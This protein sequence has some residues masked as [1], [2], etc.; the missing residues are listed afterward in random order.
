M[1]ERAA[2]RTPDSGQ[3]TPPPAAGSLTAREA[4][5]AVGVHERTVRRAI[6]RGE[7]AAAQHAGVYRIAPAD[8]ARYQERRRIAAPPG[9]QTDRP[10]PGLI[11]FPDAE[12]A[13]A[14][15]LPRPRSP[16]IGR[17]RELAAVR[18]LLLRE[19]VP[20]VTL[21]G[22]GGVGKTR[23]A[24][25]AAADLGD[26]FADG[27]W[28]VDLAPLA[29]P[30]MVPAAIAAVLGVREAGDRPLP[31]RLNAYLARRELLLLLDNFEGVATAAP[32]VAALLAAC[33][34]VT[35][36]VTSRA[37][38]RVS[39][40]HRFPVPP[41]ALTDP[42]TAASPDEATASAAVRLFAARARAVAPDFAVTAANAEAVAEVCRRLDGLPLAIELAAARSNLLAPRALLARLEARLPVLTGG[43]RDQ[44][45][46]LQTMRAAIA[47]GY[48][49]LAPEEQTLFRRLAVFAGGFAPEA[50]EWVMGTARRPEACPSPA[51]VLDGIASL[52][53][54]S[55]V[56]REEADEEEPRFSLLDTIREFAWEQVVAGDE[57]DTVA[58]AHA[59]WC[60]DLAER[61]RL[62]AY[63]PDGE[64]QLDRL[65]TEH[66]NLRAALAWLDRRGDGDRLLR[67]AAA[68][69]EYW[70]ARSHLREG[71]AWFERALAGAPDAPS[72]TRARALVGFGKLLGVQ[73]ESARAEHLLAEGLAIARAR[74]DALTTAVALVV[75]GGLPN[76][77]GL[78]NERADHDRAQRLFEEALV[79]AAAIA[80]PGIAAAVTGM[81]LAHLG[82]TAHGRGDL[83]GA[84]ARH[85]EALRAC[86]AH[87][88][89]LGV[90]RSLRDLGDVARD[91]GDHAGSVAFYRES[92]SLM[93]ERG[94][95]RVVADALAGTAVAAAAWRQPELAARLLGAEEALRERFGGVIAATDRPAHDRAI[96]T[97]RGALDEQVLKTAWSAGRGLSLAGAK[98]EAW[99]VGP[100]S[101]FGGGPDATGGTVLSRREREVL[102]LLVAGRTDPAIAEAL[103]LSVRTVEGHVARILAKLGV[104]TRTAAA[105]AALAAGLVDSPRPTSA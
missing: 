2:E 100:T 96:A 44:P 70:Y 55:L 49:L 45:D 61:S 60:L 105:T 15:P 57:Q 86:R 66:A 99:A 30:A 23:L 74:N 94:D 79:H 101:A 78:A 103:F 19:D 98:A 52:V 95:L 51:L 87:G 25:E 91:L 36:L 1:D 24:L 104:H 82:L 7:L 69:G 38:L 37:V 31:E 18:V 16:L 77:G 33:P 68:L 62:A 53:D 54:K 21:T 81:A 26:A 14:P 34:Q 84:R 4:A 65:E 67:L 64:R 46:R 43:A 35:A 76:L 88:Y 92:L 8:L 56:R 71:R 83:D 73:G 32:V 11:P 3:D 12:P 93:G 9:S 50:A 85:K 97:V 10:G 102:A 22:P 48:G 28:F 47:W 27:V 6:A 75:L 63:L 89:G 13:A 42:A 29:D 59:A 41:L 17:E 58:D 72:E 20:L 5:A 40:E 39:G 90:V 80:D